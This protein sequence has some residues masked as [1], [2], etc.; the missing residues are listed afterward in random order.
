MPIP[1]AA[2]AGNPPAYTPFQYPQVP[3]LETKTALD[4]HDPFTGA[5]F[6]IPPKS[7]YPLPTFPVVAADK[8]LNTNTNFKVSPWNSHPITTIMKSIL[9]EVTWNWNFILS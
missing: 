3:P 5:G 4:N 1:A 8:E 6:N 2:P 7:D 9:L